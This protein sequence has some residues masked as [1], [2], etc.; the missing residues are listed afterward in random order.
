MTENTRHTD[1]VERIARAIHGSIWCDPWPNSEVEAAQYRQAAE[2]ALEASHHA[3][4]E[5]ALRYA[6]RECQLY[7]EKNP[8]PNVP[9]I[10]TEEQ[11]LT[12]RVAAN[13]HRVLADID[14]QP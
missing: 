12:A 3:E 6:Q 4:L 1:M 11:Y 10:P 2:T 9:G 5:A 13:C 14:G 8:P 7:L